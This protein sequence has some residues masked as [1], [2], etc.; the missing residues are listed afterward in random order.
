MFKHTPT[1]I[2]VYARHARQTTQGT[3]IAALDELYAQTIESYAHAKFFPNRPKITRIDQRKYHFDNGWVVD[4]D[5]R[6]QLETIP[7]HRHIQKHFA[8][9]ASRMIF[10]HSGLKDLELLDYKPYLNQFLQIYGIADSGDRYLSYINFW[11]QTVA[12]ISRDCKVLFEC[13]YASNSD[14][15]GIVDGKDGQQRAS[16]SNRKRWDKGKPRGQ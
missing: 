9:D 16:D 3:L 11:S 4:L 7:S 5:E 15:P 10:D 13:V 2:S 8:R 14:A 12:L 6:T 1:A